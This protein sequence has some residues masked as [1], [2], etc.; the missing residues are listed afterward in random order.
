MA[1]GAALLL[2]ALIGLFVSGQ[3]QEWLMW[4]RGIPFGVADPILGHDVA[5]Y[6][7][8]LPFLR[9]LLRL[10]QTLVV[11]AGLSVAAI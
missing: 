10:A 7:F 11:L 1:R 2:A 6:I 5:F 8:S 3:W 4:R 9:L